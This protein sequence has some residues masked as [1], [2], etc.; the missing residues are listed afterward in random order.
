MNC[1]QTTTLIDGNAVAGGAESDAAAICTKMTTLRLKYKTAFS[2]RR[3]RKPVGRE[4]WLMNGF[5]IESRDDSPWYRDHRGPLC[6]DSPMEIDAYIAD[7]CTILDAAG[8]NA[9]EY[10]GWGFTFF[11]DSVFWAEKHGANSRL[12]LC[13]GV[14][15]K[16]FLR[17][18]DGTPSTRADIMHAFDEAQGPDGWHWEC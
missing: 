15:C 8:V 11:G 18:L 13:D 2:K 9:G 14:S 7:L 12:K 17:A 1:T 10:D 5:F 4:E 6:G 16:D 3:G